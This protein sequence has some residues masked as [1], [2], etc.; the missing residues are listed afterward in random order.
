MMAKLVIAP[1]LASVLSSGWLHCGLVMAQSPSAEPS[2]RQSGAELVRIWRDETTP[3]AGLSLAEVSREI[4]PG[5]SV[6]RYQLAVTGGKPGAVYSIV[7]RLLGGDQKTILRG[8]TVVSNG[9][10]VC[11]GREGFCGSPARPDDPVY[12]AMAGGLGEPKLVGII[13]YGGDFSAYAVA[14]PFPNRATDSGCD[15]EEVL[16]HPDA[17]LVSI[18]GY[19]FAPGGRLEIHSNSEGESVASVATAGADGGYMAIISPL[20]KGLRAGRARITI[21]SESCSPGLSFEWGQ[22]SYRL[23]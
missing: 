10:A 17:S 18:V 11:S 14:I 2:S 23:Q 20:I 7:L 16:N 3:G 1:W 13:A 12:L 22:G 15:L 4:I 6:V 21:R 5:R 9:V 19:G 8:V